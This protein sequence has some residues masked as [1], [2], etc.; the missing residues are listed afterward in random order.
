M[1]KELME[2]M[3]KAIDRIGGV[4]AITELPE[5]VRNIIT[6]CADYETRVKMLELCADQLG[7]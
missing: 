1:T 5:A 2:R 7:K 4:I 6:T 3:N